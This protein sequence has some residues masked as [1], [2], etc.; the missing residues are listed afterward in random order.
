MN[1][2]SIF[3]FDEDFDKNVIWGVENKLES[4]AFIQPVKMN[5]ILEGK[6][7]KPIIS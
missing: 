3:V 1:L 7:I 6:L 2:S 4:P 5:D